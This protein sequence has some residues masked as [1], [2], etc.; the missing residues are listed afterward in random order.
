MRDL[1]ENQI[2][3]LEALHRNASKEWGA[4]Y[5]MGWVLKNYSHTDRVLTSLAK[6]G[7]V[8]RIGDGMNGYGHYRLTDMGRSLLTKG[9]G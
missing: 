4:P 9:D 7:L 3:A 8:K 5:G 1:G 6:R 2:L